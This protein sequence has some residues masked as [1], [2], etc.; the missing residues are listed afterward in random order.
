MEKKLL[1]G[2]FKEFIQC[3]NSNNVEYLLLGGWAVVFYGYPRSTK[4]IDFLL[5]N[6]PENIEKAKKA[7]ID[8]N[9]PP[10]NWEDFKEEG[11]VFRIG[12][13]PILIDLINDASGI[14]FEECY[15]RR[16]I[17]ELDDVKISSISKEDLIKN[18]TASGR[19]QD[20]ADVGIIDNR[21]AYTQCKESVSILRC[22]K[23]KL[24]D[25][26]RYNTIENMELVIDSDYGNNIIKYKK[27]LSNET[28]C[29]LCRE[30]ANSEVELFHM[31][32]DFTKKQALKFLSD[33]DKKYGNNVQKVTI[34]KKRK[35][36]R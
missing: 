34:P 5:S 12:S 20:L 6:S 21:D 2:I 30:I 31:N 3:L 32:K 4:D 19:L 10:L 24:I 13:S 14:E 1:P 17:I 16:V 27:I 23:Y 7:L 9:G 36:K 11:H 35:T 26:R 28:Q 29:Y 15:K 18:K 25:T 33:W 8:F 22:L